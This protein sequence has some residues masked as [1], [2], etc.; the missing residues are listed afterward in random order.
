M[1]LRRVYAKT[2]PHSTFPRA[3]YS[4]GTSKSETGGLSPVRPFR[5]FNLDHHPVIYISKKLEIGVMCA[6]R[7]NG[8]T[9]DSSDSMVCDSTYSERVK[10]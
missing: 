5:V 4:E 3:G 9:G 2:S 6:I 8:C 7:A 1:T 10:T